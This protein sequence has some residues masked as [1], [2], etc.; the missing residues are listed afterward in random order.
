MSIDDFN[1]SYLSYQG[2]SDFVWVPNNI[3]SFGIGPDDGS[4]TL[5]ILEIIF[6]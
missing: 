1:V 3:I 6:Q 5:R 2:P 4:T